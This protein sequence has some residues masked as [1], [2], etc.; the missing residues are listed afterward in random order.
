MKGKNHKQDC[1]CNWCKGVRM[2]KGAINSGSFKKGHKVSKELRIKISKAHKGKVL[3]EIHKKHLSEHNGKYW[4]GKRR[5]ITEQTKEKCRISKFKY[6]S[7]Q[8]NLKSPTIGK[9]ETQILDELELSLGCKIIRQYSIC[10]YWLDGYIPELN[11][12]IEVDE[13]Y[14]L[15]RKEKD[16]IKENII[17]KKLNCNFLRIE[18]RF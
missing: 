7:K 9:H 6:N 5:N 10:G 1:K 15:K 13:K 12:A 17:K 14:H 3:T 18:D 8:H 4:L 2:K 11:L 16:K